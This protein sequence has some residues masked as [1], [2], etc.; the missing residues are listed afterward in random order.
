MMLEAISAIIAISG[1]LLITF[2]NKTGFLFWVIGNSLWAIYGL[3]TKQYFF[4]TQY[5]IFTA[6]AVFGFVRWFKDDILL[7]K[8]KE[9]RNGRKRKQRR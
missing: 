6:L 9:I 5:I 1:T 2:K 7:K 8:E 4:M 3:L